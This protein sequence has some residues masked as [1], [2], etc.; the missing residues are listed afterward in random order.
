MNLDGRASSLFCIV[1]CG[2]KLETNR[3]RINACH[4]DFL[5]RQQEASERRF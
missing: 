5:G 1:L 4:L 3:R 2:I